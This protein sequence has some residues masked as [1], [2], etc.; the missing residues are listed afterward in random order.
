M[1]RSILKI[2]LSFVG[3]SM[4][5][6]NKK[7]VCVYSNTCERKVWQ[8]KRKKFRLLKRSLA[9][10]TIIAMMSSEVLPVSAANGEDSGGVNG[11]GITEEQLQQELQQG[12]EQYPDGRIE[13]YNTELTAQEGDTQKQELVIVRRGG[14]DQEASVEF[15]AISVSAAYG[16]DYL[17]KVKEKFFFTRTLQGDSETL[18]EYNAQKSNET[19]ET[20]GTEEAMTENESETGNSDE[21][22]EASSEETVNVENTSDEVLPEAAEG[23]SATDNN[24]EEVT[25]STTVAETAVETDVEAVD[26]DWT[27]VKP[28]SDSPD[29]SVLQ[30]AKDTYLGTD[31]NKVDWRQLDQ[32]EQAQLDAYDAQLKESYND[33]VSDVKGVS[34]TFTFAPGEY[35]KVIQI[36]ILE[37]DL[38][39]S[40]EQVMFVLGNVSVGEL[41]ESYMATLNIQDNDENEQVI[42]AMAAS[43]MSVDRSEGVAEVTIQR[44]SGV[45][46]M[47]SVVVGTCSGTAQSGE[48]Y[49]GNKQ[50]ILFLQGVTEQKVEIPVYESEDQ[51]ESQFT[52]ALD[53]ESSYVLEDADTTLV[54]LTN[55]MQI[56]A[57]ND[58]MIAADYT[59][60][61]G[62]DFDASKISVRDVDGGKLV[63][64][65]VDA[66]LEIE[67]TSYGVE[68]QSLGDFD[69]T[70]AEYVD[71]EWNSTGKTVVENRCSSDDTY[72]G[73]T[74]TLFI[75][76]C[77]NNDVIE[78]EDTKT[79]D[80]Y[81]TTRINVTDA[82]ASVCTLGAEVSPTGNNKN[83]KMN[84]K[85]VRIFYPGYTFQVEN[86]PFPVENER[87]QTYS[88]CYVEKI[89]TD[90]KDANL[91]D[92]DGH[93]YREGNKVQLG[94]LKLNVNGELTDKVT[95]YYPGD[96]FECFNESGQG[97][98]ISKKVD[99]ETSN[100]IAPIIG[101]EGNAYLVGYQLMS[102]NDQ[103]TWS[104]VIP[105]DEF[106]F[107]REFLKKYKSKYLRD[108]NVFR[109]RPVYQPYRSLVA[110]NHS[111]NNAYSG[112]MSYA[113]GFDN[114]NVLFCTT[115]D[116]IEVRG[117]ATDG[118]AVSGYSIYYI[119]DS[120]VRYPT[121]TQAQLAEKANK[122]YAEDKDSLSKSCLYLSTYYNTKSQD[123]AT[124]KTNETTK[125]VATFTPVGDYTY[126]TPILSQPKLT[127]MID[128][129]K[130]TDQDKGA[131]IAVDENGNGYS[132]NYQNIMELKGIS[133]FHP[134]LISALINPETDDE[135]VEHENYKAYFKDFTGDTDRDGRIDPQE[136]KELGEYKGSSFPNNGN[137]YSF[138]PSRDS[139]LIYYGFK[140]I[141]ANEIAGTIDGVVA[142]KDKPVFGDKE[143]ETPVNNATVSVATHS[144]VTS[145]DEKYGGLTSKGG[146]GYFCVTDDSFE[147]G[148]NV[149]VN[150]EYKN[151][152]MT[153]AQTV[154]AAKTYIL[155]AYDT[156]GVSQAHLY[157]EKEEFKSITQGSDKYWEEI[158]PN[159]LANGDT[160]Y[161]L[162]IQAYS[163]ESNVTSKKAVFRFYRKDHTLITEQTVT[164]ENQ[165]YVLEFNP[166]EL[167]IPTAA[168]MTVQFYDQQDIPYYEHD[169]GVM[170]SK[171]IGMLS[172]LA[173][174]TLGTA[175]TYRLIGEI[176]ESIGLNWDAPLSDTSGSNTAWNLADAVNY[177]VVTTDDTIVVS[178]GYD[179]TERHDGIEIRK[180]VKDA[181][182]NESNQNVSAEEKAEA[183]DKAAKDAAG[184]SKSNQRF[185]ITGR[186]AVD[187]GFSLE[188]TLGKSKQ[189]DTLGE[190][191]FKELVMAGTGRV[192]FDA[193]MK[194]SIYGVPVLVKFS[195]GTK[196]ALTYY[197]EQG[198]HG[199]ELLLSNIQTEDQ[200]SLAILPF[201]MGSQDGALETYG[202][203]DLAPYV[204]LQGGVGW[205]YLNVTAGGRLDFPMK[206]YF[207]TG[208]ENYGD[209][210]GK[211]F[212]EVKIFH[213]AKTIDIYKGKKHLFG[214]D[215]DKKT[216]SASNAV[217]YESLNTM[218]V[219]EREWLE[220]EEEWMEGTDTQSKGIR[221][222]IKR[223]FSFGQSSEE[224]NTD[225]V[226][227]VL[228]KKGIH[229]NPDIQMLRLSDGKYLAVFL[230]DES[231]ENANNSTHV[232]YTIGSGD[233]WTEPQQIEADGTT[234]DQPAV[235]DLGDRGVFVAWS[236]AD[237]K[238]TNEDSVITC[239]N[240]M[241]IHGA[242]F[243]PNS[244]SFGEIQEITKT[245]PYS[246]TN[247]KGNLVCDNVSDVDP[248][249]T[250]DDTAGKMMVYYTKSEYESTSED[251]EG[252]IGDAVHPYSVIASRTYDFHTNSWVDS[253]DASEN[254]GE[255][256]AKAWY[257]QK[258]LDLA[259]ALSVR[260]SLDSTGYWTQDPVIT[261][262]KDAAYEVEDGTVLTQDPIVIESDAISY[263][264]LG[265]YA[266]TLDYDGNKDTIDDR[267]IYIQI[268]NY[269]DN[270]FTHPILLTGSTNTA[271]SNLAFTRAAGKTMLTWIENNTLY[272]QDLSN[273]VKNCLIKTE[274]NGRE[275]YY[276]DKTAPGST[277]TSYEPP[278]M[279]AGSLANTV[280]DT[281]EEKTEEEVA[282][283]AQVYITD[284]TTA[285][286]DQYVYIFWSQR[287][288]ALK[289][290]IEEGTKE[291]AEAENNVSEAQI[292]AVRYDLNDGTVTKA[293]QVT[294]EEAA[295]Y[296]YLNAV[297]EDETS[298]NVKLLA[299][300][301]GSVVKSEEVDSESGEASN[302]EYSVP[303]ENHM[304]LVSIDFTP[305][306]KAKVA[307]V[308][309]GN[310]KA[311]EEA[312]VSIG[313][314]NIGVEN[315]SGLN[316]T[317]TDAEGNTFD[318]VNIDN[319]FNLA[320]G[321]NQIVQFNVPLEESADRL[322]VNYEITDES[323]VS[324]VTG[325]YEE[326]IYKG[327]QI[328]D[329]EAT[330]EKQGEIK[331]Q[332]EVTNSGYSDCEEQEL[333][334]MVSTDGEEG[335]FNNLT[336]F[337]T[338]KLKPGD[339]GHYEVTYQY[340]KEEELFKAVEDEE[341]GSL[342]AVATFRGDGDL[343]DS[344]VTAEIQKSVTK[345]QKLRMESV[346]DITLTDDEGTE[347]TS[348][349]TMKV[350]DL[351]I[352][353]AGVKSKTVEG[354]RYEGMA[355]ADYIDNSGISGLKVRYVSDNEDVLKIQDNGLVEAVSAGTANVTVYLAPDNMV[356]NNVDG[357][358]VDE[359]NYAM[360]PQEMIKTKTFQVVVKK[361]SKKPDTP[362]FDWRELA[363]V[364]FLYRV[365]QRIYNFIFR[366]PVYNHRGRD[367]G[368]W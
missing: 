147:S 272:A 341:T 322:A 333:Q 115:L 104:E 253:Y 350:E 342:K 354:S 126:I 137:A 109:V 134:Y 37:D 352:F 268:Y 103:L 366:R 246:Y 330:T 238:F 349:Y 184:D 219:S 90:D 91:T 170:F 201:Y 222:K 273:I 25:E 331:F 139:S 88:N 120:T 255:D 338:E 29:K 335:E 108:G 175:K 254:L 153:A 59:P 42:F 302:C 196:A 21:N 89:Y 277:G 210:E 292:Y 247:E 143:T 328:T 95:L 76:N 243:D 179:F 160:K 266:Y 47:A 54:T 31:S 267:D 141:T 345:E 64:Y 101:A 202:S 188:I 92:A 249:I 15:K 185:P 326:Q 67:G 353:E 303:D 17:L 6:Y 38:S 300:K 319:G 180:A 140:P 82:I 271:E 187:L 334:L 296:G 204:S 110:F 274:V 34:H 77:K 78:M 80:S 172:F 97:E 294:D 250:Y 336:S 324:L 239:L 285:V 264:G 284:Y 193:T 50:E 186:V 105:P 220:D 14:L 28:E 344:S 197:V 360:L 7:I 13:F 233:H 56:A 156:I 124:I 11:L 242:F 98:D 215:Q 282:N 18:T 41:G 178:F 320:G 138:V 86:Q 40:D 123:K 161:R 280:V 65:Q 48:D 325:D 173:S 58:V 100:G 234:D 231:D 68:C 148:D 33:F 51:D 232:Y 43:E 295:N 66:T 157:I 290:G 84:V 347:V 361:S 169:M 309:A 275:F 5:E 313:L 191:Y 128:P 311:G 30:N 244:E 121:Y 181:A 194:E 60:S 207:F 131:V 357:I 57:S 245:A 79:H 158:E 343:V 321:Y 259:P 2:C 235:F 332:I 127:V 159:K 74:N 167:E 299:T 221:S 214:P 46:K 257:G 163:K 241:D 22:S 198:Y 263:N 136:L 355:D 10:L 240:L 117:I 226:R 102:E 112:K 133:L 224:E 209:M 32:A 135:G 293:V 315:L 165:N 73:R 35:K 278:I 27:E 71:F 318:T 260:E 119:S 367:R 297:M 248:Q 166:A 45:N 286:N 265:L 132:G 305:N 262:F 72:S 70:T 356:V 205:D 176:G 53:A 189:E 149:I 364:K 269:E 12:I 351:R 270:T 171:S 83:C 151:L 93:K 339:K 211:V 291:A 146:D 164:S 216:L 69:L 62:E 26:I 359:D 155:D 323:G 340:D 192:G 225:S 317:L 9:L 306:Q 182:K 49:E 44:V 212:A 276:V 208:L 316:V 39:E 337:T 150:V 229:P 87:D 213:F 107:S 36:E 154:N 310:V 16:E 24:S 99:T 145:K 106:K 223:L 52:V 162:T 301:T 312:V 228:L 358:G 304:T 237:R 96:S 61:E 218:A 206:F 3:D 177:S 227:E 251:D 23:D 122:R 314:A 195:I 200:N 75:T 118:Y 362:A 142:V 85:E 252:V 279:I 144:V 287:D 129:K 19:D 81:K 152:Q 125:N 281:T 199:D 168:T 217:Y 308:T 256:Y 230:N 368:W 346:D 130:T 348:S 63:T 20:D 307:S 298:G 114:E 283:E 174:F 1:L 116:T 4:I 55:N 258:F 288:V 329:L 113:N 190:W 327:L 183:S 8:M 365:V 111:W 236:T 94:N 261:T 203:F 289:D 363:I